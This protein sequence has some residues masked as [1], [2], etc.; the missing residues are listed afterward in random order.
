[1]PFELQPEALEHTSRL[2]ADD[3]LDE[4]QLADQIL[5]NPFEWIEMSLCGVALAEQ[6]ITQGVRDRLRARG[7]E[8][9]PR[10]DVASLRRIPD[11]RC[12]R[13]AEIEVPR[14]ERPADRQIRR[15]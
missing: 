14:G 3:A 2:G 9:R 13:P 12:E 15:S 7:S 8:H 5:G 11:E 1:M 10:S 6:Q 4:Q